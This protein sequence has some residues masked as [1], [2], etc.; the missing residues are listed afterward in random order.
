[1]Y[2]E[3]NNKELVNSA[4]KILAICMVQARE[5]GWCEKCC[6]TGFRTYWETTEK[7]RETYGNVPQEFSYACNYC[8]GT[9]GK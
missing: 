6:G 4:R 9:G 3:N 5:K 1:M 2:D 7:T 8:Y